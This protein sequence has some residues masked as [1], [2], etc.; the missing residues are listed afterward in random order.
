M[1]KFIASVIWNLS[2]RKVLPPLG[3]LAPYIFGLS[4]G[5]KKMKRT[6]K[7]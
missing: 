3:R 6:N 5:A 2:E 1:V 4:I 7:P